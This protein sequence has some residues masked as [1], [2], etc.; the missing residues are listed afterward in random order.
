MKKEEIKAKGRQFLSPIVKIL[1]KLGVHPH[2][3]SISGMLLS[4]VVSYF[5]ATGC[6]RLAGILLIFA[7]LFDALDGEVA[8]RGGMKS[9]FGALLDSTLDRFSEFFIFGG[10]LYFYHSN[11]LNFIIVYVTLLLSVMVSYLRAR[12]EGLGVSVDLGPMDRTGRYFYLIIISLIGKKFF[13]L[14]LIILLVLTLI[15]VVM[16]WRALYNKL[17]FKD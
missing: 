13:I 7:G 3:L 12:G 11:V 4:I 8:R 5:Y 16:R 6:F 1:V 17:N 10:L 14:F 15:T 2:F 9:T